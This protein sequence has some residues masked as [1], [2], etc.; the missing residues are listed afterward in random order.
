MAIMTKKEIAERAGKWLSSN[1]NLYGELESEPLGNGLINDTF[2]ISRSG[3]RNRYVLQRI[4]HT[5][6]RDVDLMQDN[7][8]RITDHIRNKLISRGEVEIERKVITPLS[9]LEGNNYYFDGENYWRM[10]LFI[11]DSV[12]HESV[13]PEL[14]YITGKA[15]GE[16]QYMLSDLPGRALGYTI[17]D[18]HNIEFRIKELK[19]AISSD[20]AGRVSGEEEIRLGSVVKR[21]R[22][23]ELARELLSREEEMCTAARLISEGKIPLRITH[24]DTKVNNMLFDKNGSFLCVIDLDTTMPGTVLSD[25]G[26][27]IRT[28]GNN[29]VEDEADTLKISLNMEIFKSFSKGYIE[30]TKEFLLEQEKVLLPFGAKM[31]TYMQTIRFFTDYLNGDTYYKINYPTHN[32]TR[33]IAQRTLLIDIDRHYNE[34]INYIERL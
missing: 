28:A 27:F 12:T 14:S 29:A 22:V 10:T 21:M 24:C 30:G 26:D 25:F 13:T 31:M 16:F 32:W 17:P 11:R 6:F 15:F 33:S 34:M 4:N 7:I 20:K 18:F 9:T 1:N 8:K 5:I 3:E 2:I 23:K 19:K